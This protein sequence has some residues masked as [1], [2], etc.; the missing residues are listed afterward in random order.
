ML[1]AAKWC[2]DNLAK[3]LISESIARGYER[4]VVSGHSLG[5]AVASL[6][7]V[8]MIDS[9]PPIN[10][11]CSVFGPPPTVSFPVA[12]MYDEHIKVFI[13]ENDI[14]PQLCF[15]SVVQLKE[16]ML[17]C[18]QP[19]ISADCCS[20]SAYK[21][22]S[23]YI[24]YSKLDRVL[25]NRLHALQ[26]QI[27]KLYHLGKIY[28]FFEEESGQKR[29]KVFVLYDVPKEVYSEV[30]LRKEYLMDHMLSAYTNGLSSFC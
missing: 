26:L 12:S 16:I 23:D 30:N 19:P 9:N 21:D 11:E 29:K 15:G 8:M 18:K 5:G 4:V 27:P 14:V 25:E 17:A 24:R 20:A 1:R 7:T 28:H 3:Y 10:V 22:S 2:F 6:F 13:N